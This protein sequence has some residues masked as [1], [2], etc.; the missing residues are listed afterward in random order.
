MAESNVSK[1]F[2]MGCGCFLFILVL[3]GLCLLIPTCGVVGLVG[4]GSQV[5]PIFTNAP[6][7]SPLPSR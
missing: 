5:K 7:E 2:G 4:L 3:V 1:G 6:P